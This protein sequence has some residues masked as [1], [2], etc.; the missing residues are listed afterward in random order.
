MS[1]ALRQNLIEIASTVI[2]V[3]SLRYPSFVYG[4]QIRGVPVFCFHEVEPESF[5][6]Q[7]RFLSQNGY[8]TITTDEFSNPPDKSVMLTF[9]DGWGSLWSVG[10]P[11][12]KKYDAR[13]VVF[14][15]AGRIGWHPFLTWDQA[16][17]MHRTGLA[18]F[19]SHTL[20]H[21][22]VF[23]SPKIVDFAHPSLALGVMDT[24]EWESLP[25]SPGRPI[26]E[27]YPRMGC[28]RYLEDDDLRAACELY[29]ARDKEFFNRPDWRVPLRSLVSELGPSGRFETH[30]EMMLALTH[31]L[32]ESKR[33]IEE[34]LGKEI[35]HICYPWHCYSKLA[36]E[37]SA[38]AGYEMSFVGKLRGR[39]QGIQPGSPTLVARVGGDF[40]FRL[41]GKGRIPLLRI[42]LTK[43]ARRARGK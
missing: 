7:L 15:A 39:Y 38:K 36:V 43:I 40:F 42:L 31:E 10:L 35:R 5:E 24:P 12:I 6:A 13:I 33:I 1:R 32:V 4:G 3:I 19:Q 41:P 18:D 23:C 2:D 34:H 9:D 14:L 30:E 16:G 17:E 11:L 28:R 25:F 21:S 20:T 27:S 29:T 37:L 26:Y 8:R 22:R